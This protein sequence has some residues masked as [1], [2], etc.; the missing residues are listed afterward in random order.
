MAVLEIRTIYHKIYQL[1]AY[2]ED[3][4]APE[5]LWN[6]LSKTALG[7]CNFIFNKE[8]VN[9]WNDHKSQK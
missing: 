9:I 2:S 8:P 3:F 6:P 5:E 1:L 7:E 4:K